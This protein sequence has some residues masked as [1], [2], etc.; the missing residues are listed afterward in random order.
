MRSH[1]EDQLVA[2]VRD[3]DNDFAYKFPCLMIQ[4]ATAVPNAPRTVILK[5]LGR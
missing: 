2:Q 1:V 4:V 3:D 5:E